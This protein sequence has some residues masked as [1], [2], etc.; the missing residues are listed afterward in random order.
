[1]CNCLQRHISKL[2]PLLLSEK[3][4]FQ[5]K[6]NLCICSSKVTGYSIMLIS[7][8]NIF[9]STIN[10]WRLLKCFLFCSSVVH[11]CTHTHKHTYA[12][13]PNSLSQHQKSGA[14]LQFITSLSS[15]LSLFLFYKPALMASGDKSASSPVTPVRME[16]NATKKLETVTV[17]LV[18]QE[19][20][21]PY[22]SH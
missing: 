4:H 22:V 15:F 19:K 21:V 1:M 5:Q 8:G 2:L 6:A 7:S 10:P 3:P 13:F 11:I 9:G 12:H 20:P 14:I 16:V 18:T 17:L